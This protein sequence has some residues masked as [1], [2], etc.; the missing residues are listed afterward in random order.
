MAIE[1]PHLRL[2]SQL[3]IDWYQIVLL[4]DG[5]RGVNNLLRVVK[6][7]CLDQESYHQLTDR[8][9]SDLNHLHSP[10]VTLLQ[11]VNTVKRL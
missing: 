9:S 8:W 6:Q 1:I 4:G 10:H 11:C 5:P 7:L 2:P 3:A